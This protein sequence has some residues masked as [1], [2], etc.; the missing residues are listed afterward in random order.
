MS[1]CNQPM[2]DLARFGLD[3][4]LVAARREV[5]GIHRTYEAAD[6]AVLGANKADDTVLHLRHPEPA[7]QLVAAGFIGI[8]EAMEGQAEC[9][10][11]GPVI[12]SCSVAKGAGLDIT[13]AI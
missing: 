7:P 2:S 6:C 13:L 9:Q 10:F 5:L 1:F 4:A 8:V 12:G 11:S 3:D